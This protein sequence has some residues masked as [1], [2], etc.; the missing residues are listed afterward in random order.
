MPKC[1][2]PNRERDR[3]QFSMVMVGVNMQIL[4]WVYDKVNDVIDLLVYELL[5]PQEMARKCLTP[6]PYWISYRNT[7]RWGDLRR[8]WMYFCHEIINIAQS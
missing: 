3:D 4:V 1:N 8:K 6:V 2:S 5:V 7:V